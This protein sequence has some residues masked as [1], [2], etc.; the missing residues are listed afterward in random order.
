MIL[1]QGRVRADGSLTEVV[2]AAGAKDIAS[3]FDALTGVDPR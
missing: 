3:A 2:K 1:H